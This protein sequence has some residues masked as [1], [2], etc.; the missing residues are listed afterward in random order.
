MQKRS[1]RRNTKKKKNVQNAIYLSSARAFVHFALMAKRIIAISMTVEF[2]LNAPDN[3]IY[4][5]PYCICGE[6]I[7]FLFY[8]Y[9]IAL[10]F[11][12]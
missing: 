5:K 8:R 1:Q 7:H 9:T 2:W 11:D 10:Y 3:A 6:R 12:N 4:A